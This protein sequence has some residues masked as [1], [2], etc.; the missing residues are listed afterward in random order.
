[1]V[2][3]EPQPARARAA[4]PAALAII[5]ASVG[6]SLALVGLDLRQAIV[7]TIFTLEMVGIILY[8]ELKLAFAT[9]G[10]MLLFLTGSLNPEHFA[11]FAYVDVLLFLLCMMIVVKF[12][13]DRGFFELMIHYLTAKVRS[14]YL[15][16]IVLMFMTAILSSLVGVITAALF[17]V[18]IML[19]LTL[20]YHVNSTPFIFMIVFAANVGSGATPVGSP[21]GVMF[22]LKVGLTFSEFLRWS[23]PIS[24]LALGVIVA[25]CFAVFSRD[26][27][28]LNERIKVVGPGLRGEVAL[29]RREVLE[30]AALMGAVILMI[31]THRTVENLL[32][33]EEGTAL[34]VAGMVGAAAVLFIER[35]RLRDVVEAGVDWYTLLFFAFLFASVGALENAGVDELLS[36]GVFEL[37]GGDMLQLLMLLGWACGFLSAFLDNVLVA[38]FFISVIRKL[39]LAG[40]NVYPLWWSVLFAAT[41][42][43]NAT[44]IASTAN[45]VAVSMLESR[46]AGRITFAEW[47]K[48]GLTVSVITLAVAL[49]LL[50]AQAPSA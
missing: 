19:R 30:C 39:E 25:Y 49:A 28:E 27:R 7:L 18:P 20:R 29:S 15:L 24:F 50:C 1:M 48:Y 22:A 35:R 14:A 5:T 46:K 45:I 4:K 47:V 40:V 11:K 33:L 17:M 43:G 36:H 38:A 9:A 37:C 41:Y 13:E 23:A 3:A 10:V 34:I 8:W 12:L 16:L 21:V 42:F 32:A 26:L 44:V 2:M 6:A 31:G